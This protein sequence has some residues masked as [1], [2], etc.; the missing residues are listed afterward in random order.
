[1]DFKK[2]KDSPSCQSDATINS[3]LKN[4]QVY[5]NFKMNYFDF[6]DYHNPIKQVIDDRYM[7]RVF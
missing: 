2:C 6:D 5:L 1:M 7:F 3:I 4:G